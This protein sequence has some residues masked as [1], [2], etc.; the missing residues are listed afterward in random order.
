[1]TDRRLYDT[2]GAAEYLSLAP[3]T[4]ENWR[5]MEPRRGPKWF[6]LDG[7]DIRYDKADLDAYIK[8]RKVAGAA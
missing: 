5:P 1:M 2:K 8:E 3:K 6:R 7:G 4:L